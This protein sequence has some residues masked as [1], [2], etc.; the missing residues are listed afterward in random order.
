MSRRFS[1]LS[2]ADRLSRN[3][4]IDPETGCWEWTSTKSHGYGVL[5]VGGR[6]GKTFLAHRLSYE[7]AN[8]P[9]LPELKVCHHCDNPG[10][11]NPRHLFVGTQTDNMADMAAKGRNAKVVGEDS[12]RAKLTEIDVWAIRAARGTLRSLAKQYGVSH[13]QILKIRSGESWAH[14]NQRNG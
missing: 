7:S 4:K 8:G 1:G 14:L 6:A 12:G 2:I 11:I 3:T 10:C 9:I 5:R 13:V